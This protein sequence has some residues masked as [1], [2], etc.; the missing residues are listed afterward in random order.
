[1]YAAAMGCSRAHK[2]VIVQQT[3]SLPSPC[4]LQAPKS[5]QM[6][7]ISY[8]TDS[9]IDKAMDY[10]VL[11]IFPSS[12]VAINILNTSLPFGICDWLDFPGVSQAEKKGREQKLSSTRKRKRLFSAFVTGQVTPTT[13]SHEFL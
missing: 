9:V 12:E 4:K 3:D 7:M 10:P 6:I 13:T 8:V 1:M 2:K 11:L 5:C